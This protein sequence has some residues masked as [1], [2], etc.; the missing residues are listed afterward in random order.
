ME[1]RLSVLEWQI[2][3]SDSADERHSQP[4]LLEAQECSLAPSLKLSVSYLWHFPYLPAKLILPHT[5][6]NMPLPQTSKLP[7]LPKGHLVFEVLVWTGA[8]YC[9]DSL[10]RSTGENISVWPH[11][12]SL[13]F[14]WLICTDYK[15]GENIF[16]QPCKLSLWSQ[17]QE[18]F[19][20]FLPHQRC[21]KISCQ[22]CADNL[23][24]DHGKL[25]P[26]HTLWNEKQVVAQYMFWIFFL[27][28]VIQTVV[29]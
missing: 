12:S 15:W 9:G 4:E 17:N 6:H 11:H 7:I 18:V 27:F 10:Q 24:S 14:A 23:A 8:K 28:P 22:N 2:S 1:Q 20:W 21:F 29:S 3:L 26:I 25:S 13:R 19:F 5:L 16:C